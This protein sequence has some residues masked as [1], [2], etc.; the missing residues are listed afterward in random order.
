VAGPGE[1]TEASGLV[2][3]ER[4]ELDLLPRRAVSLPEVSVGATDAAEADGGRPLRTHPLPYLLLLG[5]LFAEWAGRR[6]SG[7]R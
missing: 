7:L 1:G 6:R 4:R 2:V 5:V 3:V